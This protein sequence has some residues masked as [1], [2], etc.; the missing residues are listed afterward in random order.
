M[1]YLIRSDTSVMN[2]EIA[3]SSRVVFSSETSSKGSSEGAASDFVSGIGAE[4]NDLSEATWNFEGY[5]Q[6]GQ[7]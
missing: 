7:G 6:R 3:N 2:A 1:T 5:C 4:F